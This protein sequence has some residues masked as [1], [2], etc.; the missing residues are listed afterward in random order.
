MINK[1]P[2]HLLHVFPTLGVGGSQLRF[3]QL[4]RLHGNRYRQSV[5]A[6]DGDLTMAE[7]LSRG[8]EMNCV[9]GT[10][11]TRF[12]PEGIGRAWHTLKRIA[13][14]VLV[15]YNWGAMD[16]GI[17]QRLRPNL[18]HVHIEDGFGPEEKVRQL[19][20]RI[21]VRRFVLGEPNTTV[22]VPSRRLET[23][24][25]ETWRLP[26]VRYIPNGIDNNRFAVTRQI[27]IKK[28]E[29]VIGTVAAL[30][31]EK[32][33][34]RLIDLFNL[35]SERD[36]E[37]RLKLVIVGGGAER[38]TLQRAAARSVFSERITFAGET[39][40]PED[41][42]AKMDIFALTSDTEQMP[43][44]VLEAMSAGLPILSFDVGD[45]PFMVARENVSIVSIPPADNGAYVD[46]L[47]RLAGDATLRARV[48]AANREIAR[49]RFDERT[50]AADY[51]EVF[52]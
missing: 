49:T 34:A 6:I 7:R 40:A 41:F 22:I 38:D 20:R 29:I 44:S 30:R 23:I 50:M 31:P 5:I 48:G 1:D 42:L 11:K 18:K 32:N 14:D 28:D 3:T 46:H 15:T 39:S 2:Q 25:L 19:R 26:R 17:A 35:A 13:P 37:N 47:L 43:L 27:G 21:L 51:A 12:P 36:P 9:P 4:A 16:W 52:G 45:L 24:A 33:L 8:F 10:F